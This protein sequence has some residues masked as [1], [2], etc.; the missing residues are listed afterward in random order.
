MSSL[1][2]LVH[3]SVEDYLEGE[4]TGPVRH[5]YVAGQVFAREG[6][7][8]RHNG[9]ALNLATRFRRHVRGGPC[10]VFMSAMKVR[11]EALDLFYYPDVIVSCDPEDRAEFFVNRPCL[12]VEVTSPSTEAT[13]RRE[14][15]LAYIKL[16]SLREYV[17]I[18]EDEV[19]ADVYHR[20]EKGYWWFE[21]LTEIDELRMES[22]G[23]N[24]PL[25]ELYEDI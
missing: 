23:L 10:R 16:D 2:P 9:I 25:L 6:V 8:A 17:L 7:S 13:D 24:I 18:A 4:K 19:K 21:T 14:K 20:D 3:V 11:I 22:V 1:M 12:I 5:E 15:L